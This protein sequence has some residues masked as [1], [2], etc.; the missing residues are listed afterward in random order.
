MNEIHALREIEYEE[1]R[2]KEIRDAEKP[3]ERRAEL[4]SEAEELSKLNKRMIN[5][6]E[7][8]LDSDSL[9][10]ISEQNAKNRRAARIAERK[11][12]RAALAQQ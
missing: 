1:W 10:Y 7:N 3:G 8:N 4:D 5:E 12:L 9:E 2:E 6:L 11:R